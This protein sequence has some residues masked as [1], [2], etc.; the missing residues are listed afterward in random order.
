MHNYVVNRHRQKA[1]LTFEI[2][3][4][5]TRDE[6]TKNAVLIQ[7][8]QAIFAPQPTGYLRTETEMPQ[9]N[10]VTEIVRGLAGKDKD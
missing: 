8:T 5:A 9:V 3:V 1:L 10:Q 6:S 7:S 4:N 2:F